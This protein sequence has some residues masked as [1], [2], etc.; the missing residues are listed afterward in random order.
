MGRFGSWR[1]AIG[2]VT[3]LL[4][5]AFHIVELAELII[6]PDRESREDKLAPKRV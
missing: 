2:A 3:A 4:S 1:A 6:C 5:E